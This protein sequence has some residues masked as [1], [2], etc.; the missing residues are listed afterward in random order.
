M[1]MTAQSP[2]LE[3][4]MRR[5]AQ[6][7]A[8]RLQGQQIGADLQS[9]LARADEQ[10]K[11]AAE[12]A[13]TVAKDNAIRLRLEQRDAAEDK[14][15]AAENERAGIRLRME[16]E[17]HAAAT[18]QRQ[19]EAQRAAA[20]EA[21]A[22]QEQERKSA[23]AERAQ[24]CGRDQRPFGVG[25]SDRSHGPQQRTTALGPGGWSLRR[26]SIVRTLS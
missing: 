21:R 20:A 7:E 15:R 4:L 22:I 1:P 14:Q 17:Q 9:G 10:Q 8:M 18:A 6:Q 26:M 12:T 2:Y 23:A 25:R 13:R 3:S 5:R 24:L 11:D 19:A 16:G